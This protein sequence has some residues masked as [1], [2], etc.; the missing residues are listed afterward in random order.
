MQIKETGPIYD[1][2]YQR[3]QDRDVPGRSDMR[4][5]ELVDALAKP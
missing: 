4:K 5:S 1:M 2:L 3:A